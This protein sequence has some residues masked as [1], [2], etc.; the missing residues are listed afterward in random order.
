MGTVAESDEVAPSPAA[1]A[2][3]LKLLGLDEAGTWRA[4]VVCGYPTLQAVACQPKGSHGAAGSPSGRNCWAEPKAQ[5][6]WSAGTFGPV[7][8]G[9]D[10]DD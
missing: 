4:C 10:D 5:A 3:K 6:A 9:K 7:I 2:V 1:W 8:L